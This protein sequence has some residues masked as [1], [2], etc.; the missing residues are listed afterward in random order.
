MIPCSST[1]DRYCEGCHKTCAKWRLLQ[2]KNRLERQRKKDYL[3]YY[4]QVNST[5]P[6][7][8]QPAAPLLLSVRKLLHNEKTPLP[9]KET[10]KGAVAFCNSP[11]FSWLLFP[12]VP[13]FLQRKSSENSALSR[14]P[15][16][17]IG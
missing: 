10:G 8:P 15:F 4:N 7:V 16:I 5:V 6:A 1:C 9:L 11:F 12:L 13:L 14:E 2:A 17:D 3:Q